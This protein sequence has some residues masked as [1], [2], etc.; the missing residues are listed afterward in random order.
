[1]RN[2]IAGTK[3][4]TDGAAS[5]T[6]KYYRKNKLARAKKLAYDKK[7]QKGKVEYRS[8]HNKK[9][10]ELGVYGKRAGTGKELVRGQDGKLRMGNM[11]KNRK[12]AN[13]KK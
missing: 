5:P 13:R 9:A 10:R 2:K 1:M 7:Y 3:L 6:T 8:E 4:V 12:D 11:V